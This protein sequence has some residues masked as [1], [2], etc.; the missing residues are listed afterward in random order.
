MA[1]CPISV[2]PMQ[3]SHIGYVTDLLTDGEIKAALRCRDLTRRK[4][5]RAFRKNLQDPDERNFIFYKEDVP[6]GWLCL[7]GMEGDM[8]WISMLVV[9][10]AHRRQGAG[11]FAVRWGEEFV[12]SL[13]FHTM[14]L[15]TTGDN[16]PAQACYEKLGYIL[17]KEGEYLY[18][19]GVR[20]TGL[21]IENQL[22]IL[23]MQE[24]A[25]YD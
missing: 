1:A 5:A 19:D 13:G 11:A 12:K 17:V 10:P 8:A 22:T 23:K 15:R 9:H 14:G 7:N 2:R 24:R 18:Y 25:S 6:V 21:T 4:W 16:F 3:A 20:R